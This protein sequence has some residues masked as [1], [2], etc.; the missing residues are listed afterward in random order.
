MI[1]NSVKGPLDTNDLGLTLIHEHLMAVNRNMQA[2]FSDWLDEDALIARFKA[3]MEKAKQNGMKT[4]VEASPIDLGRDIH[5]L[6]RAAD[7]A[8]VQMLCCSGLYW[9]E[10]PW[11][12]MVDSNILA[13]Y[14][15]REVTKGIQGTD[16][17]AAFVKCST[18]VLHGASDI[19]KS[20]VI[21][22]AMAAKETG[23]PVYTHTNGHSRLGLYQQDLLMENGV[24][25]H[26][27]AIGHAFGGKDTEYLKQLMDNGSYVSCDQISYD[28]LICDLP[29]LAGVV[30]ELCK[31]GYSQ[32]MF[33]SHDKNVYSDFGFCLTGIRREHSGINPIT[34]TFTEIFEKMIPLL[35][36]LGVSPE[37][38]QDMM[39]DNPKRYFEGI[40]PQMR[41]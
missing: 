7:E 26:K 38:I 15:V 13:N 28:E 3:L 36:E 9:M 25:P 16:I 8:D 19:N 23:V 2:V 21:A 6:K 34:G 20:M 17:K 37:C 33:M 31:A 41:K 39:V 18:D 40:K 32:Y 4:F 5:L 30:A 11:Y 1:I 12:L 27:I 24:E 14:M 10:Q 35:G 22:T 29:S